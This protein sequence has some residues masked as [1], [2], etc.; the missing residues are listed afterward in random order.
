MKRGKEVGELKKQV[1]EQNHSLMEKKV[2]NLED[3]LEEEI[4]LKVEAQRGEEQTCRQAE[5]A[6]SQA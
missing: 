3:Q 5:G 4:R 1:Q 2:R 6:H